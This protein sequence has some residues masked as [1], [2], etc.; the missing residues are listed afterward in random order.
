[1]TMIRGKHI[2]HFGGELLAYQNN[3]TAW[4]NTNAGALAFSGQYTQQWMVTLGLR[5]QV[6]AERLHRPEPAWSMRTSCWATHKNWNAGVSPEYG[7]RLKSPQMFV[8]DD[9]K[10]RPE[11]HPESWS[12][13]PDQPWLERS[14]RT[15]CP[16]SIRPCINP[17][18]NT[19]GAYWFGTHPRQRPHLPAGQYL[20]HVAAARRHLPGR[21]IPRPRFAADSGSTPTPGAWTPTAETTRAMGWAPPSVRPAADSDQT[22]G[23]TP[24]TKLDGTGN[25]IFLVNRLRQP[26]FTVHAGIHGSRPPTTAKEVGYIQYHTPVPRIY[27]WNLS[28]QRA[29]TTDLCG[30]GCLRG[31]PRIE[32]EL[33]DRSQPGAAAAMLSSND[34]GS[35]PLSE[36]PEHPRQHQQRRLQ[37][38]LAAG[39]RSPSA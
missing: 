8:Q 25:C 6:L 30:R 27:Q 31:Q 12:P 7:A 38:Q 5:A 26:A 24:V 37:L 20:Q 35:P 15:I 28:V 19:L 1:M 3:S 13:L 39:I 16:A 21:S 14:P 10:V 32:P 36:L 4:G 2:L 18:T 34:S 23:I 33:P 29:L 17:A 9:W 22:N 11:P